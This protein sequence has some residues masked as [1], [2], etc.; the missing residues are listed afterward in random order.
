MGISAWAFDRIRGRPEEEEGEGNGQRLSK[1]LL[2][3]LSAHPRPVRRMPSI[4]SILFT[5]G[6]CFALRLHI[7]R[8]PSD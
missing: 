6:A 8:R 4:V 3:V 5:W 1:R 7:G 2:A